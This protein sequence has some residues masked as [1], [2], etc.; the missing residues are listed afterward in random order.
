MKL[1]A[2]IIFLVIFVTSMSLF[3]AAMIWATNR[4]SDSDTAETEIISIT[5]FV[6][7]LSE[8][9]YTKRGRIVADESHESLRITIS[10]NQRTIEHLSGYDETVVKKQTYGNNGDAYEEF[11][12]ALK[13]LGYENKKESITDDSRGVCPNGYVFRYAFSN[14][15][16]TI[17]S[18]WRS[19]CGSGSTT[20]TG[21]DSLFEKQIPDYNEF[22]RDIF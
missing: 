13:L 7:N 4:N 16:D 5:D 22:V 15:G 10:Q 8:A 18:H 20:S 12:Y 14:A 9:T 1:R 11:I 19:S 2:T 17:L 6:N 3:I 21:F